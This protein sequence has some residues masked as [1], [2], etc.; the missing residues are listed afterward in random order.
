MKLWDR[1]IGRIRQ[2][3]RAL[4][5][6]FLTN[7]R[8]WLIEAFGGGGIVFSGVTV[9]PATALACTAVLDCVRIISETTAALPLLTYRR[10]GAGKER[11]L[12]H[13]LYTVLHDSANPEQDAMQFREMLQ[14][15]LCLRGNAYAEIVRDGAGRVRELWP[16]HPDKVTA[17][18]TARGTVLYRV[19]LPDG[20]RTPNG[21]SEALL[22]RERVLHLRF[23]SQDGIY[24]LSPILMGAEAIGLAIAM[25]RHGATFFSNG[26]KPGG[27]LKYPKPLLKETKEVLRAEWEAMHG[28]LT[29]AHRAAILDD[30]M[31]WESMGVRNDH[32][33]WLDGR[34]FQIAEIA[35]IYRMPLHKI[36]DLDRSSFSN[37]E[38]QA[39]EFVSDTIQPWCV[40]WEKAIAHQLLTAAERSTYFAEHLL[41]GL[42][43]GDTLTRTQ[44]NQLQFMHGALN[45]D[46]WRAQENRNPLPDGQGQKYFV[47]VN[48]VPIERAGEPALPELAPAPAARAL[49]PGAARALGAYGD[50]IGRAVRRELEAIRTAAPK[51]A[52]D[53]RAWRQWVDEFY[54]RHAAFLAETL[55]VSLDRARVYATDHRS[56]L[57]AQGL[58]ALATWERGAGE[59]LRELA[60]VEEV[61]A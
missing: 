52:R 36:S 28:G 26:A 51:Y 37:I 38:Q 13:P 56:V 34:K 41:D 4:E 53:A 24:G 31:T 3:W 33:E 19:Q 12:D 20:Q 23:F 60:E 58:E 47:P 5:Q 25:E 44:S 7:P 15:H 39:I 61:T 55:H 14:G 35:R 1:M 43:R 8:Q 6:S 27:Y 29:N 49:P 59:E 32:A 57:L 54:A 16:L 50:A 11:A 48:L 30:G 22:A 42:L 21:E 10:V 45:L 2:T 17:E 40:R 46:E 9:T 18:R